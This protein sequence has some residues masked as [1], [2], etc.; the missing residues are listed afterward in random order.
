MYEV[1]QKLAQ[2]E[3][4]MIFGGRLRECKYYDMDKVIRS[5]LDL[6]RREL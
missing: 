2:R 1:Y 6:V 5:S 3:S 4:N